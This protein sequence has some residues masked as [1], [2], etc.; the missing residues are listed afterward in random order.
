MCITHEKITILFG[1]LTAG[2]NVCF[3]NLAQNIPQ[4][5]AIY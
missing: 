5:R 1:Y 4:L 3:R 2:K